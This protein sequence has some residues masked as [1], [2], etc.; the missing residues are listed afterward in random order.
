MGVRK[1]ARDLTS[2]E[3]AAFVA[4]VK[5]LK[6]Q[7][8]GRNYDWFVTTHLNYFSAVNGVRYAHQS[9]FIAHGNLDT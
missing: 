1:N 3:K 5:Q 8:S 4:A 6:A 2:A 7:T 9:P